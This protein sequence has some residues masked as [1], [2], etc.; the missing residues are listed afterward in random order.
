M[1]SRS[2]MMRGA[3]TFQGKT[4]SLSVSVITATQKA[5]L[6]PAAAPI[7]SSNTHI[8]HAIT[9]KD[10][11]KQHITS[12]TM[13]HRQVVRLCNMVEQGSLGLASWS[14]WD[15]R[16]ASANT[17]SPIYGTKETW[18]NLESILK[19]SCTKLLVQ[20]HAGV[21]AIVKTI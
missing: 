20:L 14:L 11:E 7:P 5:F 8:P 19:Y 10:E 18:R 21:I 15:Y 1:C 12:P 16:Q 2:H 9:V 17:K 3:V 6:I 4:N 13:T